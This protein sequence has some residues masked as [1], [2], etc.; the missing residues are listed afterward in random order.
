MSVAYSV[1]S[2]VQ[3]V[4]HMTCNKLLVSTNTNDF[5]ID[6]IAQQPN[7]INLKIFLQINKSLLSPPLTA[8][9]RRQSRTQSL[10]LSV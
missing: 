3:F 8:I 2:F 7:Y 4:M 6:L 10:A 9:R 1:S 5:L